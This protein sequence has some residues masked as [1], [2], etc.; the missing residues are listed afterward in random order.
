MSD[1]AALTARKYSV[2]LEMESDDFELL[3]EVATAERLT[4]SDVIRRA[5]RAY[6][7]VAIREARRR[8]KS[9][10]AVR[11]PKDEDEPAQG[12]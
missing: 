10:D 8:D 2:R 6:A 3:V 7:P 1:G 12:A 5:L 11:D 4:R 9:L